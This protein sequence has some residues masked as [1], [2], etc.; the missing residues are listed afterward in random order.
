MFDLKRF[1]EN[2]N[3]SQKALAE[4]L[5]IQQPYISQIERGVYPMPES[6]ISKV[7]DIF[8][9]D[10][11][12]EYVVANHAIEQDGEDIP[13]IPFEC[14]AGYGEDNDG[15]MLN[16][17]ERYKIPEFKNIG[18]EFLVRVGGNSMYPKYSSGD[19]LACKKIPRGDITF[20]QWGKIY[21]IDSAQGQIIKR[22]CEHDDQDLI[23]L[24]SD[25]KEKLFE[26]KEKYAPF[27]IRK[28]EI[29]SL[30]IVVGAVRME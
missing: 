16:E 15:I 25:N 1:R 28:D 26:G 12:D 7:V 24:V 14:I 11:I 2:N 21:V 9:V 5:G 23:W 6:L 19:I 13:L 30:S 17:C 18:A 27:S 4:Q 20:F 29:R 3:L 10:N 22:V 8:K